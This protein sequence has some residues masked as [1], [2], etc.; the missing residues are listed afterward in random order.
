MRLTATLH[1]YDPDSRAWTDTPLQAVSAGFLNSPDHEIEMTLDLAGQIVLRD[2]IWPLALHVCLP[3]PAYR[4]GASEWTYRG[5]STSTRV[6]FRAE[7]EQ[8]QIFLNAQPAVQIGASSLWPRLR[9]VAKIV[10]Q[11]SLRDLGPHNLNT[12]LLGQA[13]DD[14]DD[15]ARHG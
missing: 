12:R 14:A 4:D 1:R 13:L 15:P 2:V 11:L 5:V 8:V 6:L 7:R 9:A 3:Q 10:H